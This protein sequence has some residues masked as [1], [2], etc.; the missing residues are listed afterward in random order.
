MCI[1]E[2]GESQNFNI[3]DYLTKKHN[4]LNKQ[5]YNTN[6]F[7]YDLPKIFNWTPQL[8]QTHTARKKVLITAGGSYTAS[9]NWFDGP[10]SWPGFLRDLAGFELCMD[11]SYPGVGNLFIKDSVLHAV[12]NLPNGYTLDDCFVLPMWT[13][14]EFREEPTNQNNCD[15]QLG[16]NFY[17]RVPDNTQNKEQLLIQVYDCYCNIL[18]LQQE[19]E[20]MG[21]DYAYCLYANVLWNYTIPFP[22]SYVSPRFDQY[23][24]KQQLQVL[25]NCKWLLT[26][27]DCLY[28]YSFLNDESLLDPTEDFRGYHPPVECNLAWTKNNLIPALE[29]HGIV[30][31]K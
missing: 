7:D 5:V 21:A 14:L 9:T 18:E 19:L 11:M 13:D 30:Q 4:T 29:K 12:D 1:V 28:E 15:Y 26:D 31:P 16:N 6:M 8:T 25:R 22:T 24:S 2:K 10:A 20:Q 23:L 27:D 17:H 3:V